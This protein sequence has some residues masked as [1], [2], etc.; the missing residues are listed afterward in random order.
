MIKIV[1]IVGR[2]VVEKSIYVVNHYNGMLREKSHIRVLMR[3]FQNDFEY[4]L[5]SFPKFEIT[6]IEILK[7]F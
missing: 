1:K 4:F 3:I 2:Y 6:R 7:Y 5:R